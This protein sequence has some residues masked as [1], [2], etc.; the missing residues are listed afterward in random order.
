[1]IG[2]HFLKRFV[3]A[4]VIGALLSWVALH[5]WLESFVYR[6]ELNWSIFALSG[7]IIFTL[8]FLQSPSKP[9]ALPAQIL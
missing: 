5:N 8:V 2:Y 6:I 9:F 3:L 4:F 1:M 7:L